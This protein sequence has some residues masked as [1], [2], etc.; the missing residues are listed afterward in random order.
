MFV[1][2]LFFDVQLLIFTQIWKFNAADGEHS[3]A[4][5]ENREGG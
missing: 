1:N 4:S 3:S 5:S 2:L